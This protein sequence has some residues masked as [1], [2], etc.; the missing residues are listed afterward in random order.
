MDFPSCTSS[1]FV[2]G[3]SNLPEIFE[4]EN[5]VVAVFSPEE[6]SILVDGHQSMTPYNRGKSLRA[7][8][9]FSLA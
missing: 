6:T 7:A 5:E 3:Y 2:W 4:R 1:F 8:Q 9:G